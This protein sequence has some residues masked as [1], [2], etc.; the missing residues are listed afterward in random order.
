VYRN[1]IWDL[2]GTMFDTY[3]AFASAFQAALVDL[4][5]D[6]SLEWITDLAKISMEHCEETLAEKFSLD[7]EVLD[8]KFD[9]HYAQIPYINQEP[10]PGVMELCRDIYA[11]GGKNIIVT[12]RGKMGTAALLKTHAIEKYFAGTITHDDGYPKKP[13]PDAFEAVLREYQ[14]T[15]SETLSVGDRDID[16]LAARAVGIFACLFGPPIEGISADLTFVDY[17]ELRNYIHGENS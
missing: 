17:R 7:I 15:R 2:D 3:P 10:F 12:H 9:G 11:H 1:I 5:A 13:A 6:A 4:G 16:V 14:L 8:G